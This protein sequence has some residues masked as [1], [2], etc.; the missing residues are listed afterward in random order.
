MSGT[1]ACENGRREQKPWGH[2][3]PL[4]SCDMMHSDFI[5]VAKGGYCSIH[6]HAAKCNIFHVRE[7]ELYVR[8]FTGDGHRFTCKYLYPGQTV[9]V[10]PGIWHQFWSLAGSKA[11]EVYFPIGDGTLCDRSDIERHVGLPVGGI[12]HHY[13]DL[14]R[15]WRVAFAQ[16]LRA[17]DEQCRNEPCTTK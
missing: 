15:K 16:E 13:E 11:L 12:D 9:V 10:P 1:G 5:E 14:C 7:G 4:F 17:H 3:T 8:Q 2:T 6:S